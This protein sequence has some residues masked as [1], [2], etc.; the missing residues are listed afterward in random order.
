M[1]VFSYK[2]SSCGDHD[3]FDWVQTC[4]IKLGNDVYVE[5]SYDCYG[6]V[7]VFLADDTNDEQVALFKKFKT[8][9]ESSNISLVA[10]WDGKN[11]KLKGNELPHDTGGRVIDVNLEQF[12][13]FFGHWHM[14]N[15]GSHF[16]V[17]E[18]SLLASDIWCAGDED[19]CDDLEK[20]TINQKV[21]H[22]SKASLGGIHAL[23]G[24]SFGDFDDEDSC[25]NCVPKDI[26]VRK[27]LMKSE[28]EALP[29]AKIPTEKEKKRKNVTLNE[30]D[31]R[32]WEETKE[33]SY[34][35]VGIDIS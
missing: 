26:K 16:T 15:V 4:V 19:Q 13:Q 10:G 33:L 12:E 20:M 11:D 27:Y 21:S 7:C 29:K 34:A 14:G 5:G 3:Q 6:R 31:A 18:G 35:R 2:C 8:K 17:V 23:L 1:G 30:K 22:I 9:C 25:R 32:K 28:L 24:G